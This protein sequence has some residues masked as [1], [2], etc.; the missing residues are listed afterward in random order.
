LISTG[1]DIIA[2][3]LINKQRTN[4]ARFYSQILSAA[5]LSL[6]NPNQFLGLCFEHYI[7][8]AWSVKES[9]YKYSKRLMPELIFSPTKIVVQNLEPPRKNESC[10]NLMHW[11][12]TDGYDEFYT[13][14]I[15]YQSSQLY[16]RSKI[17]PDWI[18]TVVSEDENF[19]NVHWGVRSIGKN[20]AGHQSAG[21]R[22][23]LA[24]K[25]NPYFIDIQT[26]KSPIGYPIIFDQ[27]KELKIPASLAHHGHYVSYSCVADLVELFV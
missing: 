26:E 17:S 9:V 11:E 27:G 12:S 7:W 3:D 13:G 16:F 14:T 23:L 10:P 1:N 25:L 4:Q 2:L 15:N 20:T 6:Y 21:A 18:A 22:L 24:D 5:E 19:E 8:L